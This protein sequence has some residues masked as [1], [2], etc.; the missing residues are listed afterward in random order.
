MNIYFAKPS[1]RRERVFISKNTASKQQVEELQAQLNPQQIPFDIKFE[2]PFST[3][4]STNNILKMGLN[5][6]KKTVD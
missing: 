5:D 4:S 1:I 6:L 3:L 2:K